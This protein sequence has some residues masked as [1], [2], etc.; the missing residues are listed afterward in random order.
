MTPDREAALL[1]VIEDHEALV[2]DAERYRALRKFGVYDSKHRLVVEGADL[3][4]DAD[5]LLKDAK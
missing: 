5:A 4:E 2:R 3:D 1:K